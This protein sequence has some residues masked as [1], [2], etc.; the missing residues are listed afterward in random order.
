MT[1]FAIAAALFA[2]AP[3]PT[4]APP[5]PV[6]PTAAQDS[7]RISVASRD[8]TRRI[9]V[10]DTFTGTRIASKVCR[11]RAQWIAEGVDPLAKQ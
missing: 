2:A 9:C 3:E 4:P 1:I 10:V 6:A 11:T 5:A 8:D 7:S